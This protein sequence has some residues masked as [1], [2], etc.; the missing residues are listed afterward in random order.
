M[1]GKQTLTVGIL[2]SGLHLHSVLR[3][4]FFGALKQLPYAFCVGFIAVFSERD[5]V[6]Y[7]F[8][9]LTRTQRPRIIKFWIMVLVEEKR[10]KLCICASF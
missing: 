4:L 7:A 1:E 10:T 9:I 8:S 2:N 3:Y 6:E 5:R